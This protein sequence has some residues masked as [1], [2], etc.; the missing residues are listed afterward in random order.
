M[1]FKFD[2]PGINGQ[3]ASTQKFENNEINQFEEDPADIDALMSLEVEEHEDYDEEEVNTARTY[4]DYETISDTCSSYCSKSRR[5]MISSSAKKS[6]Q[7]ARHC[8]NERKRQEM[9]RMV[10]VLR[11]IMPGG[12]EQMDSVAVIDEAVRYLKSLKGEV[13]ELGVGP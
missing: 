5:N 12:S 11:G 13:E 10:K 3:A 4:E 8:N 1:T 7:T 6:S 9:K 2:G